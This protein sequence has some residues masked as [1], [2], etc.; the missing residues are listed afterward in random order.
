VTL[1]LL[2]S[3]EKDQKGRNNI[4]AVHVMAIGEIGASCSSMKH[5]SS[6][7]PPASVTIIKG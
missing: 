6:V 7:S 2:C 3:H 1:G 5:S 4:K